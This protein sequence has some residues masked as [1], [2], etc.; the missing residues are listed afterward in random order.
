MQVQMLNVKASH[1]DQVY[2]FQQL[3]K[4]YFKFI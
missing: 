1:N 4:G 3:G 2:I